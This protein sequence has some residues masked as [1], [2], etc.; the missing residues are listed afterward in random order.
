MDGWAL[1]YFRSRSRCS[2]SQCTP[3]PFEYLASII[4]LFKCERLSRLVDLT[5]SLREL[6]FVSSST[7]ALASLYSL[8]LRSGRLTS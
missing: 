4:A 3:F 2:R 1:E 8:P 5:S 6:A 7:M